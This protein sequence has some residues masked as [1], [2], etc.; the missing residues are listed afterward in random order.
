MISFYETKFKKNS[1]SLGAMNRSQ[2]FVKVF[3]R[4][5]KEREREMLTQLSEGDYCQ[6]MTE[7]NGSTGNRLE[8]GSM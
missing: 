8:C 6:S 7:I 4:F 5:Q 2:K 1:I 3:F